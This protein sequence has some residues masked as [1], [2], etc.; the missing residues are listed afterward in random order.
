MSKS[1]KK[2]KQQQKKKT[3]LK[4]CCYY[5]LSLKQQQQSAIK[6]HDILTI[7]KKDSTAPNSLQSKIGQ[8]G[9]Q[10]MEDETV[11][12]TWEGSIGLAIPVWF[13]HLQCNHRLVYS[14]SEVN[15]IKF[16][17]CIRSQPLET[18]HSRAHTHKHTTHCKYEWGLYSRVWG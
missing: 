7:F 5:L 16:K 6:A 18:F 13:T 9:I 14:E 4:T 3:P 2:K 8:L 1:S 11:I 15:P 10:H 12:I 17:G